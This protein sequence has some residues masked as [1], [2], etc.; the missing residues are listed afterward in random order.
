MFIFLILSEKCWTYLQ[1]YGV[2]F[3]DQ[4]Y[5]TRPFHCRCGSEYCLNVKRSS[6]ELFVKKMSN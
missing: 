6:S 5:P 2:E 1:D 3:N 4:V